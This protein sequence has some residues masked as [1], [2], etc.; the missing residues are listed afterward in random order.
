[1][2]ISYANGDGQMISFTKLYEILSVL[3]SS[4]GGMA[5]ILEEMLNRVCLDLD[6]D[7]QD[8]LYFIANTLKEAKTKITDICPDGSKPSF[9]FGKDEVTP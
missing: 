7:Q 6:V 1:M 4:M 3:E 9:E 8:L 5:F 2:S